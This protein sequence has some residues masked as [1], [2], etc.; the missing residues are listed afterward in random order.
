MLG[1]LP[2]T[3]ISGLQR[4]GGKGACNS[5]PHGKKKR[6][7][8]QGQAL[9]LKMAQAVF[10]SG[11]GAARRA[12]PRAPVKGGALLRRAGLGGGRQDA[13]HPHPV[14][15]LLGPEHRSAAGGLRALPNAPGPAPRA[16]N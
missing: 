16:A 12:A 10:A 15:S 14:R 6:A 9:L 8:S 5:A 13:L 2:C 4:A 3:E 11:W 7:C 1:P